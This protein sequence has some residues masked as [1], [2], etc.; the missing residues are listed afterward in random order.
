MSVNHISVLV[1]SDSADSITINYLVR[2]RLTIQTTLIVPTKESFETFKNGV[3]QFYAKLKGKVEVGL[4]DIYFKILKTFSDKAL[5]IPEDVLLMIKQ[6]LLLSIPRNSG[7][8]SNV[9]SG[10]YGRTA[11]AQETNTRKARR[12][13]AFLN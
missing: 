3:V 2:A 10:S 12:A 13:N 9:G 6:E 1:E 8:S 7:K 11:L 5:K 4:N